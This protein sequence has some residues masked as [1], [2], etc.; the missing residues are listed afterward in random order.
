M[1]WKTRDDQKRKLAAISSNI[2]NHLLTLK[3]FI[4]M[5][6]K[7]HA[8]L[9]SYAT[10]IATSLIETQTHIVTLKDAF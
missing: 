10:A 4:E 2:D 3:N 7:D 8:K 1:A 5:Y 9:A 6:E